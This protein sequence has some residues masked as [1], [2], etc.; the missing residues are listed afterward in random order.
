ME[1]A[2]IL[3]FDALKKGGL[4]PDEREEEDEEDAQ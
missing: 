4:I 2:A 3:L 1:M